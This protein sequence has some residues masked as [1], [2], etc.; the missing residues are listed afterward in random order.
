MTCL[1]SQNGKWQS[2]DLN[3]G[4][5]VL[6]AISTPHDVAM[7]VRGVGGSAY[8]KSPSTEYELCASFTLED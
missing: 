6:E 1:K 7:K 2:Q 8:L 3:P 4:R 5:M